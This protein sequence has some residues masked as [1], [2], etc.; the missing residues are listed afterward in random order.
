MMRGNRAGLVSVTAAALMMIAIGS[1]DAQGKSKASASA[2]AD[3][4]ASASAKGSAR[5]G[6]VVR[7]R[8]G[9]VIWRDGRVERDRR[10]GRVQR[11]RRDGRTPRTVYG[12]GTKVPPGL[13]KKPGQM[14]P[15]Q[16]KKL[17]STRQGAGVLGEVLGRRGYPV[18][19]IST[20]GDAHA[21]YYRRPDG[22]IARAT[23]TQRNDRLGFANI[24][25][26]VLQEVLARLY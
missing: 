20:Y 22:S 12:N 8:D 19:G 16:Y 18:Q 3:K 13:A 9:D 15:G 6:E 11:D 26:V 14:P 24:P 5:S 2:K 25:T 23:V 4:A 10:D 21:V 1:A 7:T 17:Y